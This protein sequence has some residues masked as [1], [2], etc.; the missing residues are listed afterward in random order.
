VAYRENA[1]RDQYYRL[2]EQYAEVPE[3]A[4]LQHYGESEGSRSEHLELFSSLKQTIP[5]TVD[6][7]A[8]FHAT[9]KTF[10]FAEKSANLGATLVQA[11]CLTSHVMILHV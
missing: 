8:S 9:F 2:A 10:Y 11:I 1:L 7:M 5:P 6:V 4:R 3:D